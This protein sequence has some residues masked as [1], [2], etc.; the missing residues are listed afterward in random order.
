MKHIVFALMAMILVVG[1]GP[2]PEDRIPDQCIRND[3]FRQCLSVV[4]VGPVVTHEN[5]W[6]AVVKECS[7]VAYYQS[8]RKKSII[9]PA[10]GG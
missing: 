3:L 8:L 7:N 2:V 5:D 10:C 6:A 1:C 9:T 4:P